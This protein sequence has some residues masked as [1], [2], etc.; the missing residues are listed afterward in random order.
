MSR[1]FIAFPFTH[2]YPKATCSSK[3]L[4][5]SQ[6]LSSIVTLQNLSFPRNISKVVFSIKALCFK[7]L[8]FYIPITLE[9]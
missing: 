9:L 1:L 6:I 2:L 4:S 5:S 7:E 3:R 8:C